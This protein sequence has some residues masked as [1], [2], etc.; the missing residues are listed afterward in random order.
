MEIT[1][2]DSVEY[3][4]PNSIGEENKSV[5]G[6]VEFISDIFVRIRTEQNVLLKVHFKNFSN[7]ALVKSV[8][9]KSVKEV[10]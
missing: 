9:K 7:L 3:I 4:F 1:I 8:S 6:R 2:G 10:I 5:F